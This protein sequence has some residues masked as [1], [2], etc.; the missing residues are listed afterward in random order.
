MHKLGYFLLV[1]DLSWFRNVR[2]NNLNGQFTSACESNVIFCPICGCTT[3]ALVLIDFEGTMS[4]ELTVKMG[5]VLKNVT[6]ASEEGWL[7]GE[8]NGKR[9]I[10]PSN[11]VK[12]GEEVQFYTVAE[13]C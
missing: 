12:V 2:A 6:K 7:Q 1:R 10:F 9:G 13:L 3:E 4:D 5:D 8:L 11:F